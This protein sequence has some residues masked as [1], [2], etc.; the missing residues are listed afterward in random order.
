[1][2]PRLSARRTIQLGRET[3]F[4]TARV[5]V[6]ARYSMV[7]AEIREQI[8]PGANDPDCRRGMYWDEEYQD[9]EMYEWYKRLIQVRK[10]HACIVE[11]ELAGIVTEDEEGTVVLIRKNGEE[12]IAM[13]FN[14]SSSAKKFNAYTEKYNLLTENTFD[15][16]VEGFDAAVIVL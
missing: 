16:K 3:F 12:T 14:C 5:S 10:S 11:G 1:M 9:K 7:S 13:I 2:I 8:V 4:R 6:W 15:G